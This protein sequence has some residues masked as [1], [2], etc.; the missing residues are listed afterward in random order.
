MMRIFLSK[1]CSIFHILFVG[2]P[3]ILK[4]IFFNVKKYDV[5]LLLFLLIIR[6]HWYFLKGE[7][8]IS[9]FEKKILLPN[10]KLGDANFASPF[11]ELLT[12]N[13]KFDKSLFKEYYRDF[14]QN[15]IIYYILFTNVNSKNFN[16]L[17]AISFVLISLYTCY[18][19]MYLDYLRNRIAQKKTTITDLIFYS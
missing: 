3:L 12:K 11:M 2:L 9:F 1:F 8:I 10:Y 5:Y 14:T 16:L 6:L 4:L 15:L 13:N 18:N 17:V 7:C 19:N